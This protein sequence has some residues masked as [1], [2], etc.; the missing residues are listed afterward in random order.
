M[1][2]E[3]VSRIR[4]RLAPCPAYDVEKIES[5][6]Q[7]QAKEGLL[8]AKQESVFAFLAFRKAAP[9]SVRYRLQP[10]KP[11]EGF[12]DVPDPDLQELCAEYGWE[13]VDSYSQ[14]HIYRSIRPDAREMDTDLGVQAAAMKAGKR[15]SAFTL[16]L[17]GILLSSI[18][19]QFFL[20]PFWSLVHMG[21]GY[22]LAHLVALLWVSTDCFLQWYHLRKLHKQLKA[23]IPLDHNKPWKQGAAFHT[24]SKIA[25]AA[26]LVLLFGVIL[27]SCT[28]SLDLEYDAVTEYP[29][30]PPFVTAAEILPEGSY[31]SESFL[32]GFNAYTLDST[33]FAPKILEWKEYGTITLPDGTVY[34]GSL[35]ITYYETRSPWLAEGLMDDLYR[36]AEK[37]SHFRPCPALEMEADEV[38]CFWDIYPAILIRQGNIVIKAHVGLEHQGE[39]LLE[40]WVQQMNKLLVH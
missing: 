22:H 17:D 6:L 1:N 20:M 4:F 13:Y 11:S 18:F 32:Q 9:Q 14:F 5:W 15:S 19:S 10:K 35:M 25:Y 39:Y 27:T 8:L 3:K 24:F 28:G 2:T 21:L 7:D 26:V 38:L 31:S 29:G 12:A 36:S 34:S 40:T 23:N 33:F 16:F 30:D 37:K